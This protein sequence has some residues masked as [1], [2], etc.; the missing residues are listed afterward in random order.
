MAGDLTFTEVARSLAAQRAAETLLRTLGGATVYVRVP[1]ILVAPG[2]AGQIGL[3]GAASEDVR[4]DHAVV[5]NA[6]RFN[7]RE[8]NR[9]RTELLVSA[10]AVASATEIK[11]SAAAKEFFLSAL[12]VVIGEKILRVESFSADEYGGTP[13]LYRVILLE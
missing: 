1:K 10:S 7:K 5:R 11:D 12:G 8:E 9:S 2:D 13:Y 3:S 4:L 6:R